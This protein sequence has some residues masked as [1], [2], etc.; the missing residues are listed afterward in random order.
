MET[1]LNE[2]QLRNNQT[3]KLLL[4]FAMI[5][6]VMMFAGLTSAV[7]V[8]SSR[9]DWLQDFT[10]P[11]AFWWSTL[12]IIISSFTFHFA[13]KGIQ[14]SNRGITTQLLLLTLA[15]ALAFVL[16][17]FQGFNQ[18]IANGFYFTGSNSTITTS[19]I[20]MIVLLHLL[21]LAGGV[22]AILIII[23]NHFKQK[24]NATQHIGIELGSIFWHFLGI[25]WI[26]LFLFLYFY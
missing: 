8:S 26:L 22:I 21:H 25:L 7:I 9:R 1:P 20:Y 6:M 5:S 12:V 10:L 19:F 2:I 24:Y 3:K 15:L 11:S 13:W 4:Y 18:I 23:Y 14:K 16:L 17:Q